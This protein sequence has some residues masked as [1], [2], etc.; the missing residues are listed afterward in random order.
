MHNLYNTHSSLLE[1]FTYLFLIHSSIE[2]CGLLSVG[3]SRPDKAHPYMPYILV[4]TGNDFCHYALL[5]LIVD[6][7][8]LYLTELSCRE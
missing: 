6:T 1:A 3:R 4:T 5:F 7:P 8:S 2:H